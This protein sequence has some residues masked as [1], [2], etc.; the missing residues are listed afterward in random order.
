M[1]YVCRECGS[2]DVSMVVDALISPNSD[3][4]CKF[5]QFLD[6]GSENI[7]ANRAFRDACN[8]CGWVQENEDD[9]L[10]EKESE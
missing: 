10:I 9:T 5:L 1:K 2:S 8:N 4:G 7:I 3:S 6:S